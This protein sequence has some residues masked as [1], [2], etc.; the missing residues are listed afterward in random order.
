MHSAAVY[1]CCTW[2]SHPSSSQLIPLFPIQRTI[3]WFPRITFIV[4]GV[5]LSV[6]F[7]KR[8]M[9]IEFRFS[10]TFLRKVEDSVSENSFKKLVSMRTSTSSIV[11][12]MLIIIC[13]FSIS[14]LTRSSTS[15]SHL[16]LSNFLVSCFNR[17]D[18][19]FQECI[20]SL[21]DFLDLSQTPLSF[22][23]VISIIKNN[24]L[25]KIVPRLYWR[26]IRTI[27]QGTHRRNF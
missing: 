19:P 26:R 16:M 21:Q 3:S 2:T 6:L 4:F 24:S 23:F 12:S 10:M 11:F 25:R 18:H 8:F 9:S 7:F 13:S 22:L 15:P 5:Q 17:L 20:I 1:S 27:R 14:L